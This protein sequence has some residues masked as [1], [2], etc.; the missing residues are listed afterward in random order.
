MTGM[1][2]NRRKPVN[3]DDARQYADW[4]VAVA[5]TRDREAFSRLFAHF[6]PRVKAYMFRFGGTAENA[7]ELAQEAMMQVWRKAHL[8][9]PQK[10][11]ASTWIFT[12]ARN[13]RIDRFRQRKHIEVDDADPTLI[14]DESPLADDIVN[15]DEHAVL[16]HAAL[17][18]LPPDQKLVVELSFFEECSHSEIAERL[19]IPL[20]TVKSRLRLALTKLRGGLEAVL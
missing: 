16:I 18:D 14:V 5:A 6:G 10:A 3:A 17:Q 2:T 8:F 15:R 7:E 9:D 11:A 19:D 1:A 4:I 12:I 13:L 20:G